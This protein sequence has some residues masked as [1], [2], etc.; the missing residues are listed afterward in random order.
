MNAD[1]ELPFPYPQYV[2]KEGYVMLM[3]QHHSASAQK[4]ENC[5][6]FYQ[7][8]TT[9]PYFILISQRQ[10]RTQRNKSVSQSK[11]IILKF[12]AYCSRLNEA[13]SLSKKIAVN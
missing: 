3:T 10:Y 6:F 13:G 8:S 12:V 1:N 5:F 7:T 4:Q 11:T 9:N 2:R